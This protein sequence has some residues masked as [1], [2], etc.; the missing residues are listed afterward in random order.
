MSSLA[1]RENS[2]SDRL[3]RTNWSTS[4]ASPERRLPA[5]RRATSPGFRL[6]NL[7]S[8][9]RPKVYQLFSLRRI[10]VLFFIA[11]RK[12]CLHWDSLEALPGRLLETLHAVSRPQGSVLFH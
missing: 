7:R 4:L 8:E 12:R 6:S 9:S 3:Q 11:G 1:Y 5:A 2:R 10:G